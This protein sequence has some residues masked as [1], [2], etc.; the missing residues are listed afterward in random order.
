MIKSLLKAW[1]SR[2]SVKEKTAFLSWASSETHE[3][4]LLEKVNQKM[5]RPVEGL[6][7]EGKQYYEFVN[8]A[9]MPE[10]R[11]VHYL[12]LNKELSSGIA[13]E[14]HNEY[15]EQMKVANNADDRSKVGALIYMLQDQLNNCTPLEVLYKLAALVYFDKDE[16]ISCFDADYNQR[17]IKLFKQLPNQGFF[18]ARLLGKGLKSVGVESPE[19]IEK[20][21]RKSAVRINAY[22]QM[23]AEMREASTSKSLTAT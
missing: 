8:T 5:I 3:P 23:L 15:L 16:D 2:L 20:Y 22:R 10:A 19:D 17:K 13:R 4:L 18:F 12:D 14:E 11:F 7:I 21:L 1:F 6:I 9:D